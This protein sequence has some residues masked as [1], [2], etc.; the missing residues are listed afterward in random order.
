VRTAL[1]LHGLNGGDGGIDRVAVVGTTSAGTNYND[2][3]VARYNT[4]GSLDTDFGTEGKVKTDFYYY[5]EEYPEN[6]IGGDEVA[7]GVAPNC[8]APATRGPVSTIVP[9]TARAR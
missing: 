1:R 3:A 7:S 5:D 8:D 2:F 9:S 6:N 4:N